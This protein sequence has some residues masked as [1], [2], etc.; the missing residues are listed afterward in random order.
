MTLH[1]LT[2]Q[3]IEALAQHHEARGLFSGLEVARALRQQQSRIAELEAAMRLI[4]GYDEP[5]DDDK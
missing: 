2:A 3:E 1:P 5:Q 4:A